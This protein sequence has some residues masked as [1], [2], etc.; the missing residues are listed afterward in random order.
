MNDYLIRKLIAA[1]DESQIKDIRELIAIK[2]DLFNS[3]V[4][5]CGTSPLHIAV[6][7]EDHEVITELIRLGAD[8]NSL[9]GGQ[10]PLHFAVLNAK[11]PTIKLLLEYRADPNA[12]SKDGETPMLIASI[13]R[14]L[15]DEDDEQVVPD[16]LQ[17]YGAVLDIHSAAALGRLDTVKQLLKANNAALQEC[18][19]S[20]EILSHAILTS[21]PELVE[22]LLK[23]GANPNAESKNAHLPL[24]VVL[25]R[26][27][28]NTILLNL[29][30][31]FGA[32]PYA[33]IGNPPMSL[34]EYAKVCGQPKSI[35]CLLRNKTR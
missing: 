17:S 2:P 33:M 16:L 22:L 26:V 30:L 29:L 20:E 19:K 25:S 4:D 15:F 21:N 6:E 10:T 3:M 23:H 18:P 28:C 24:E 5:F 14:Q 7:N 31:D 13:R 8:I 27:P 1:I 35:L 11:V 9:A 12:I 34:Y 32:D